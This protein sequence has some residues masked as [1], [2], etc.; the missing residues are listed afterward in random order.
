[1]SVPYAQMHTDLRNFAA[2]GI[3]FAKSG[4]T[5]F[6]ESQYPPSVTAFYE[7]SGAIA[8]EVIQ[9]EVDFYATPSLTKEARCTFDVFMYSTFEANF[10]GGCSSASLYESY[11]SKLKFKYVCRRIGVSTPRFIEL[12]HIKCVTWTKLRL[13]V[14]FWGRVE[15]L[16][17]K[18]DTA[19]AGYNTKRLYIQDL[20]VSGSFIP[21]QEIAL[22]D[23]RFFAEKWIRDVV[24]APSIQFHITEDG[25]ECLSVHNQLFYENQV[26]YRGC[27]SVH[28][29]PDMVRGQ[30]VTEGTRIAE[31]YR[32]QGYRGHCGLNAVYT[33]DS[34]LWWLELNPRRVA[35]SYAFAIAKNLKLPNEQPYVATRMHK[36][37]W[38]GLPLTSILEEIRSVLYSIDTREGVIPYDLNTQIY[39]SC[40][41]FVTASTAERIDEILSWIDQ[42]E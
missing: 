39:G 8:P 17:I 12:P 25:V 11:V 34:G 24:Y 27:Q 30:V 5:V 10:L 33:P 13:L 22:T 15:E 18:S 37:R 28:Y 32:R 36:E 16:I 21:S 7:Q 41:F 4:D 26:T 3:F 6:L 2:N 40:A 9:C 29:L 19:V 42:S 14:F 20:L 38:L 23:E 35:S 1:M 31:E